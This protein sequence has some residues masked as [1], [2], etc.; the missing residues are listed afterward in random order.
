MTSLDSA[1]SIATSGLAAIQG[2]IAIVSQNVANAGTAGYTEE[3]A[4]AES[5]DAGNLPSG[6]RLAPTT[7]ITAPALQ[8]S[9]LTQN[10]SVAYQATLNTALTA[11]TSVEG[12][13][14]ATAGSTGSLT[15]YLSD[16]QSSFTALSSDPSSA[17]AQ[18]TVVDSADSLATGVQSLAGA[19]ASQRQAA[20]DGVASGVAGI[21]QSLAA[22]GA[23]STQIMSLRSQGISTVDL[24]SQRDAAM[25]TLSSLVG[26]KFQAQADGN[27]LVS[28]ANGLVLPTNATTGPLSYASTTLSTDSAY[29]GTGG[30]AIPGILLGGTDVT[31]SLTGGSLGANLQLRDT[32]LPTDMAELDQFASAVAT[33]FSAQGLTLFTDGSATIPA[34]A[35]GFSTTI[36]VNPA[37]AATP[38]LVRDGTSAVASSPAGPD[39]FTP[40]PTGGP[41]GFATLIDRV[42]DNTFGATVGS[43]GT[44]QSVPTTGLGPLGTLSLPFSGAGTLADL[45]SNVISAQGTDAAA[46]TV[47]LATATSVQTALQSKMSAA[48]GVSID[49]EMS[50]MT[51][52]ENS[53]TANAKVIA[54]AQTMFTAMLDAIEV[55]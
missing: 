35:T 30:D 49:S 21:N 31:A 42:L 54:T 18:T 16:L 6:V 36:S 45:A 29:G 19:Y 15:S 47:D 37:V 28:T 38:S 14:D 48:T 32:I 4:S 33:R 9:L 12:T 40:N 24:E 23:L 17:A 10:A 25:S 51:S 2:Q 41:A 43:S 11:I 13:T 22:I 27:M 5:V 26:V 34:A 44:A 52:L 53:Y 8:Q 46:S 3:V 55:S 39:A 20:S 1:L 50:R 7:R